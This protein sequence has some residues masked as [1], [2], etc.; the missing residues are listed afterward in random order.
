MLFLLMVVATVGGVLTAAGWLIWHDM[1]RHGLKKAVVVKKEESRLETL[2]RNELPVVTERLAWPPDVPLYGRAE[3][4]RLRYDAAHQRADA[5][6]EIPSPHMPLEAAR[7]REAV[8]ASSRPM[9][10][11]PVVVAPAERM[12]A[13]ARPE[14]QLRVD[15]PQPAAEPARTP[16]RAGV[17]ERVLMRMQE[18]SR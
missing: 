15:T 10:S 3:S 16:Q 11:A 12:A 8:T 13:T 18:S 1:R 14:P 4:V 9:R 2:I 5:S 17:L 6:P 7:P